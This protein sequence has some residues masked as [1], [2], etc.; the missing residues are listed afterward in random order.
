[1]A[2]PDERGRGLDFYWFKWD[3]EIIIAPKPKEEE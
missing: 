3:N 2:G 1:L